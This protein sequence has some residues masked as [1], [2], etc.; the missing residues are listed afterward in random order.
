MNPQSLIMALLPVIL[1]GVF[2]HGVNTL[3]HKSRPGPAWW[4]AGTA[5]HGLGQ[6]LICFRAGLPDAL[7][8]VLGDILSAGGFLIMLEGVARFSGR[9]LPRWVSGSIAA[10]LVLGFP[11]FTWV[12]DNAAVRLAIFAAAVILSNLLM[13]PYL[14]VIGRRDGQTGVRLLRWTIYYFI[15]SL[16]A[17]SIGVMLFE[18]GMPSILAPSQLVAVGLLS[19]F[20]VETTLIFG[21]VLLSSGQSVADLRSAAMT[22]HLTGL[23]NRRAFE[24]RVNEAFRTSNAAEFGA[25]LAVFDID[26]FK[27]VND[28]HG[29]DVGDAVLRHVADTLSRCLRKSDYVARLGG[30]EFVAVLHDVDAEGFR[31]VA[32]R[33]RAAVEASPLEIDGQSIRVTISVGLAPLSTRDAQED[34]SFSALFAIADAALYRA[35]HGGRN[36]V[37][38]AAAA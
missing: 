16:A 30:E 20:G 21:F 18:P 15:F 29:H 36:Q 31:L 37:V 2:V 22:D 8:V 10:A 25:A 12:T 32:D 26:H 5:V 1:A 27:R 17:I 24:H 28:Q 6:A 19:L 38:L 34:A 23:P 13:L 9:S 11:V 4:L 35:K 7:G 33:V 3:M 14:D